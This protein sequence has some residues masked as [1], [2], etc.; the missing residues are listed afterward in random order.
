MDQTPRLHP[1]RRAY[2]AAGRFCSQPA[3][4]IVSGVLILVGATAM[5]LPAD[6]RS[7]QRS[8]TA[9]SEPPAV[10]AADLARA[11]RAPLALA[12]LAPAPTATP[13]VTPTTVPPSPV[14][15]PPTPTAALPPS[16][17]TGQAVSAPPQAPV[18][19]PAPS[20]TQPAAPPPTPMPVSSPTP[21]PPPPAPPP[22]APGPSIALTV[23]EQT[24]FDDIN[25]ARLQAGLPPLR[26][27]ARVTAV[28]R[29]RSA[30][31]AAHN[32]FSHT[33]PQG[34]TAFDLLT[35]AGIPYSWAGENLARNNYP[36][37]EA[38]TVAFNALMASPPHRENILG[39]DYTAIG[40]GEAT[41]ASGMVYFTMI[42]I[43]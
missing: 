23:P 21:V 34:Q 2:V 43:G 12:V 3:V 18:E 40:V 14:A 9:A 32:Y 31:M 25:A 20:P 11:G 30:D 16:G 15:A 28:A 27:D 7:G 26:L 17:P 6:L 38:A 37:S 41:D 8:T 24:L 42:F 22:A 33:N 29:A 36:L 19:V 13:V 35:Q 1:F 4:M 10:Y 5:L 39:A